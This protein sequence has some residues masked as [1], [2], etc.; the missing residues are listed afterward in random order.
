M[1][2]ED[3]RLNL[4]GIESGSVI[5]RS[6]F[7][8]GRRIYGFVGCVGGEVMAAESIDPS[9]AVCAPRRPHFLRMTARVEDDSAGGRLARSRHAIIGC[10]VGG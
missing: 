5:L 1:R 8:A 10:G 2:A 6:A 9:S 3:G 4:R 7:F